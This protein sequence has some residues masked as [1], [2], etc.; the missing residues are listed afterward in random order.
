M[1]RATGTFFAGRGAAALRNRAVNLHPLGLLDRDC[2]AI[3]LFSEAMPSPGGSHG[4][5]KRQ[6][7]YVLLYLPSRAS[8]ARKI[9]PAPMVITTSPSRTFSRR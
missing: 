1:C 6:C 4:R 8:P 9:S 3:L 7:S 5:C 2:S